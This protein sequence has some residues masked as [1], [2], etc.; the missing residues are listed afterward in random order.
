[1]NKITQ[2]SRSLLPNHLEF[3]KLFKPAL[4]E[5]EVV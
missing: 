2:N 3:D 1:M 4:S 5:F